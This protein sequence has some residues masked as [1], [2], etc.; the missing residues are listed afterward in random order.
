VL[1]GQE[2]PTAM[3]DPKLY[4]HLD[5]F[6]ERMM[7][8]DTMMYM[9]DDVLAKMDRASMG[10]SLEGRIPLL[11][12]R[13]VEF[14]WKV[15]FAQKMRKG[16]GKRLLRQVLYKYIP[17]DLIERPKMGFGV[18]IGVWLRNDLR[19]W[20]EALL[21]ESRLHREGYFNVAAVREKWQ[22]H[23]AGKRDW[24]FHLWTILMFQLWLDQSRVSK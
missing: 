14:A 12:H 9:P 4:P 22:E 5:K 24:Q 7:Y 23:L 15:P 18:P 21:E 3:S 19:D 13:V 11:D 2:Y 6:A 1:G 8:A 16:Q 20:A 10:V 17:R